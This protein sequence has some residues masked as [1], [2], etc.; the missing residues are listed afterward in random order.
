M[1]PPLTH[2]SVTLL[3]SPHPALQWHTAA[4]TLHNAI[5]GMRLS[6]M[7]YVDLGVTGSTHTHTAHLVPW[8]SVTVEDSAA[9][10]GSGTGESVCAAFVLEQLVD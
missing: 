8:L 6:S 9:L 5:K 4:G 7:E 3:H 1:T 10:E 2:E